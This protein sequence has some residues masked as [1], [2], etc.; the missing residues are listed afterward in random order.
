M[1]RSS[2]TAITIGRKTAKI[3]SWNSW[4]SSRFPARRDFCFGSTARRSRLRPKAQR[5]RLRS[6]SITWSYRHQL[7]RNAKLRSRPW[8]RKTAFSCNHRFIWGDRLSAGSPFRSHSS[9]S[10]PLANKFTDFFPHFKNL[11]FDCKINRNKI[12]VKSVICRSW[13]SPPRAPIKQN[14]QNEFITY[15]RQDRWGQSEGRC[16]HREPLDDSAGKKS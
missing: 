8:W 4:R 9:H 16:W 5:S 11:N 1:K 12:K 7:T 6:S 15:T 13:P 2:N 14:K 3:A 10:L